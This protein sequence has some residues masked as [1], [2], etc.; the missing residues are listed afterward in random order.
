[1]VGSTGQLLLEVTLPARA[2]AVPDARHRVA[3]A[4][5]DRGV[6]AEMAADV[7]LA[8]SEACTNVVKHAYKDRPVGPMH[9]SVMQGA[10]E[11]FITVCDEGLGMAPRPD[12]DGLG[13]GLPL[14][15]NATRDLE[16][17]AGPH[18]RGTKLRMTFAVPA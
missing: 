18:G 2:S 14:I 16:I 13:L 7:A 6:P 12:S 4:L 8:L 15:V 17:T 5:D 9:L 1:M 11:L 10:D 3:E